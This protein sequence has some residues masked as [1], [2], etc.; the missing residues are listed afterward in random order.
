MVALF[1][2][3][4]NILFQHMQDNCLKMN[5]MNYLS[6]LKMLLFAIIFKLNC[7]LQQTKRRARNLVLKFS[8]INAHTSIIIVQFSFYYIL[9][10]IARSFEKVIQRMY[11]YAKFLRQ[12]VCRAFNLFP[13]GNKIA[14]SCNSFS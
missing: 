4:I 10:Y 12:S 6:V 1:A 9:P 13:N 11:I 5:H 7:E 14:K 3:Y 8:V 2:H